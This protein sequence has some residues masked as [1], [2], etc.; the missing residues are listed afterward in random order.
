MRHCSAA[1]Q[2]RG[3]LQS[4]QDSCVACDIAVVEGVQ[5][6][7]AAEAVL[8][9]TAAVPTMVAFGCLPRLQA[10]MRLG[11]LSSADAGYVGSLSMRHCG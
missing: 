7:A 3:E 10:A 11:G 6:E 4:F 5:E 9:G 8:Q 2:G 1:D